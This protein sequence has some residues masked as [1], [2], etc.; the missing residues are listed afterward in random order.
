MQSNQK[1]KLVFMTIL[2]LSG[3]MKAF[4]Q[5]CITNVVPGTPN[6]RFTMLGDE[7]KD[8]K[9]QLIWQRCSIGQEWSG[10][11]CSGSA[12]TFHWGDALVKA[13]EAITEEKRWRLPNVKELATLV[14]TACYS[15]AINLSIFP[16]TDASTYW[17]S[18]P[19]AKSGVNEVWTV[20]FE[21]GTNGYQSKNLDG[22]IR[23]V[24]GNE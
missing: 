17:A 10:S 24:R 13:H 8:L 1:I 16:G 20:N 14:E 21:Q 23:L 4:A 2:L 15:P 22:Y 11:D 5:T 19:I 3:S 6:S 18:S 12:E 9:T 7:V